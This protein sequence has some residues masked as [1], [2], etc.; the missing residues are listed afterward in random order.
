MRETVPTWGPGQRRRLVALLAA[1]MLVA[2]CATAAPGEPPPIRMSDEEARARLGRVAVA[3]VERV[4][5][6]SFGRPLTRGQA[7][8]R[9]AK[10]GALAPLAA[11]AAGG[12]PGA[13]AAL[14]L[15][16]LTT[17]VGTRY[18]V[19]VVP[20]ARQAER[21]ARMLEAAG[22]RSDIQLRLRDAVIAGLGR[23]RYRDVLPI[24]SANVATD[25]VD[26]V[27]EVWVSEITLAGS[28][29]PQAGPEINPGLVL[30][31]HGGVRVLRNGVEAGHASVS[32][33]GHERTFRQW[34][35]NE[36]VI[37]EED[38][39]KALEDLAGQV[40]GILLSPSPAWMR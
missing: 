17:I 36:G 1:A 28:P 16:P 31:V 9:G 20:S 30:G 33:V 29:D 34:A 32:S 18:G 23:E 21:A 2:G 13:G 38:L 26:S 8:A 40:V 37:F 3:A 7:A 15:T 19:L 6:V 22:S 12:G 24:T 11:A 10:K 5:A 35:A 27:L 4:P 14:L 25:G 39:A